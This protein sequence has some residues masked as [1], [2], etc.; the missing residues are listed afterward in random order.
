MR[1]YLVLKLV[2]L[3]LIL[4]FPKAV[5]QED[6]SFLQTPKIY[7][8][9]TFQEHHQIKNRAF[10]GIP[11]MAITPDGT[12]WSVWYAG[13]TPEEDQNNY[14]V[15]S[16]SDNKGKD[17]KEV[18]VVD[19]DGPGSVRAFDPEIWVDPDGKLWVFWAQ[20]IGMD[21]TEAGVWAVHTTEGDKNPLQWSTPRRLTDGIMM[22]KPMV[23]SS[24]EWVLPASTWRL[25]DNSA[26]MVISEDQGSNWHLRG[27]VHV[28]EEFRAYDEHMIVE[29]MDGD[30]WML[31]RTNYGIGE[32]ISKDRGKTWS[33]LEPGVLAHPSA[34]FFIR[35]LTSGSLLLVKHGPLTIKTGRSHLM[36]FLSDNDGKTWS[37]GL[38]LDE[39]PGISYPDGQQDKNGEIYIIYDYDRRGEQKILLTSFHET[40]IWHSHA[41]QKL[42]EVFQNRRVISEK[43]K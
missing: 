4:N 18:L 10:S 3:S 38:L 43:Q 27:A 6:R 23:L 37:R 25:T 41:D 34:R 1:A 24:G 39:R 19:P 9:S 21:G 26:K 36:A 42:F 7:G 15:L 22:C 35:R 33:E 30:L 31:V 13:I 32:S 28:P 29:K 5:G 8:S 40:D 11:S 17:W 16:R 12:F 14:V 2:F 20:T